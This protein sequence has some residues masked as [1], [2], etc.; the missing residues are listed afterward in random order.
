[1][2]TES[3]NQPVDL[4]RFGLTYSQCIIVRRTAASLEASNEWVDF[5]TL[6]DEAAERDDADFVLN[7]VFRLPSAIGGAWSEEKVSLTALGLLSAGTAPASAELMV[8]LTV[9]CADKRQHQKGSDRRVS[10][11]LLDERGFTA[12]EVRRSRRLVELVPGLVVG[13]SGTDD[14]WFVEPSRGA[15]EYRKVKTVADLQT[16]LEKLSAARSAE[17][18]RMLAV[19]PLFG[20]T[21]TDEPTTDRPLLFLSWGGAVSLRVASKLCTVLHARLPGIEVFFSSKSIDPG[22]DPM[23]RMLEE[24]LLKAQVLVAVLTADACTRPWVIWE[25]ASAWARG[26]LVIPVFVGVSP[27]QLPGPLAIRVQGV[28]VADVAD[29]D[30]AIAVIAGRF[31]LE[32]PAEVSE[33]E[34]LELMEAATAGGDPRPGDTVSIDVSG[35]SLVPHLG[36]TAFPLDA[37]RT[38]H[39]H[40]PGLPGEAVVAAT[41]RNNSQHPISVEAFTVFY[42]FGGPAAPAEMTLL[43]RDDFPVQNPPLPATVASGESISWFTRLA[44]FRLIESEATERGLVVDNFSVEVG[45][46]SG[47]KIRSTPCRFN[48]LPDTDGTS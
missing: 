21:P 7:D 8:R 4:A 46:G 10:S 25:V 26:Q 43:G 31:G 28:H 38:V 30:R 17:Y 18:Q 36:V 29:L 14:D 11:T 34:H 33:P 15:L 19:Q 41:L 22:D 27:N 9:I 5:D 12:D 13:P 1:M 37:W 3:S 24:G 48:L 47:Q 6:A 44:T 40:N 16:Y 32:T 39:Q 23:R 42:A 45:L 2:A 20:A 35:G